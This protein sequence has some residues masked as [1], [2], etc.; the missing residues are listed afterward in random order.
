[1]AKEL[2]LG[3]VFILLGGCG[4]A[5]EA[6][7]PSPT[8]M[9]TAVTTGTS[10]PTLSTTTPSASATLTATITN[11]PKP[12][13][14]PTPTLI[15]LTF[16]TPGKYGPQYSPDLQWGLWITLPND[17]VT[18]M[19]VQNLFEEDLRWELGHNENDSGDYLALHWSS[20]G[21]FL[22]F[23]SYGG[24]GDY[25][26][27]Q[28]FWGFNEVDRLTLATGEIV[29]MTGGGR[30]MPQFSH[31]GHYLAYLR[32]QNEKFTLLD[33]DT[34]V[35]KTIVIDIPNQISSGDIYWSPDNTRLVY[36]LE[37]EGEEDGYSQLSLV[38]IDIISMNYTVLVENFRNKRHTSYEIEWKNN[39]EI[40]LTIKNYEEDDSYLLINIET[41]ELTPMEEKPQT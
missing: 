29:R 16:P 10:V 22:Y 37:T 17:C 19:I 12:T 25:D 5:N 1:M 26:P 39:E 35:E 27:P 28:L 11:T 40:V 18:G 2:L 33:L 31:D 9:R 23:A 41:G 15:S 36:I 34:L 14:T 3:L 20:D 21:R 6:P 38:F 7:V 13:R 4:Q 32:L 30:V 8:A 24:C